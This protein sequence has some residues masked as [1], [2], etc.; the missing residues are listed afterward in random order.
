MVCCQCRKPHHY[1]TTGGGAHKH[2]F[3]IIQIVADCSF[4]R[5]CCYCWKMMCALLI[6]SGM[7]HKPTAPKMLHS[8]QS[9]A[10]L[11][12]NQTDKIAKPQ[13]GNTGQIHALTLQSAM[14]G[15]AAVKNF[16]SF[17]SCLNDTFQSAF[18]TINWAALPICV[19]DIAKICLRMV[20]YANRSTITSRM[21]L[22]VCWYFLGGF[23]IWFPRLLNANGNLRVDQM[24]NTEEWSQQ[25]TIF[26][27]LSV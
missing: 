13:G 26:C 5:C 19:L 2:T 10:R 17:W 11:T 15:T 20:S 1:H 27:N 23:Q 8:Q 4:C 7:W 12:E 25:Q 22:C 3:T 18:G 24:V 6:G 16:S 14:H 9:M 21:C